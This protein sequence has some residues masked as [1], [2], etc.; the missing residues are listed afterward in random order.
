[1]HLLKEKIKR[2]QVTLQHFDDLKALKSKFDPTVEYRSEDDVSD[3]EG[4]IV[5]SLPKDAKLILDAEDKLSSSSPSS[6]EV[7]QDRNLAKHK[8]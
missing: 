8:I 5:H 3:Y 7:V 4:E 1:M 2:L 6:F